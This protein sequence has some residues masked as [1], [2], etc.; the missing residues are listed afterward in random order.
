MQTVRIQ[1]KKCTQKWDKVNKELNFATMVFHTIKTY[2]MQNITKFS[3][4]SY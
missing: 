1:L 4:K 3:H 2:K